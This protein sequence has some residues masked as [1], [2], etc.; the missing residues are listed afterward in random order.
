[1][2]KGILDRFEGKYAV[3]E[4]DGQTEDILKERLP[5]NVKI[6]DTLLFNNNEISIDTADTNNREKEIKDLMDDLFED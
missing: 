5:A 6:G 2:R 1:M 4:F 3:I